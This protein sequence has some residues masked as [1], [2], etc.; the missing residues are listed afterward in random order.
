M[1]KSIKITTRLLRSKGACSDQI[2]LF[3][4][5][6]GDSLTITRAL[7]VKHASKFNWDWAA[8]HLLNAAALSEYKRVRAPAFSEYERV[9]APAFFDAFYNQEHRRHVA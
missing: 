5:L 3:K 8:S 2:S 6:G 9:R 1:A 7:C 4:E